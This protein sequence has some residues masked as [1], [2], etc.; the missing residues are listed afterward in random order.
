MK[1]AFRES[2]VGLARCMNEGGL[3]GRNL[4]LVGHADPR[5]E[6]DY[7]LA[8]GGRRA[9]AVQ[10]AL[11]SL[12]VASSRVETSSRGEIDAQGTTEATW[13]ADRRVDVKL[14]SR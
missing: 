1:S 14:A 11:T 12:R 9:G 13:A 4:L 2:L 8:L 6:D 7:N 3:K 5:G 10:D